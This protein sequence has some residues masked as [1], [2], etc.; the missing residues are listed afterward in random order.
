MRKIAIAFVW[1]LIM[2]ALAGCVIGLALNALGLDWTYGPAFTVGI[3]VLHGW[4]QSRSL[5]LVALGRKDKPGVIMSG[6]S[7][8]VTAGG[9]PARFESAIRGSGRLS[10]DIDQSMSIVTPTGVMIGEDTIKS[11]VGRSWTRQTAG[12][13]GLSRR[14][15]TRVHRPPLDREVYDSLIYVLLSIG[16]IQGRVSGKSGKLVIGY[17][18][19]CEQ[20]RRGE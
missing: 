20:I 14:Y 13:S 10:L 11:F 2:S 12:R 8:P 17:K 3:T 15:W 7:I 6:R 9:L 1:S 18:E 16:A 19:I 4:L 5:L